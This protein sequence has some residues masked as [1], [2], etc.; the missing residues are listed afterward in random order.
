MFNASGLFYKNTY[1]DRFINILTIS[2]RQDQLLLSARKKIRTAIRTAFL[3]VRQYLTET[4]SEEDIDKI[5]LI[6]PK[7]MSQG[8]YVYKTLNLPCHSCQEIDLDDGVYLPMTFF[9]NQPEANKDWFFAIVDGALKVLALQEGWKFVEKETCARLVLPNQMHIDVPLYAIPDAQ[10]SKLAEAKAALQ[11]QNYTLSEV[12]FGHNMVSGAPYLLSEDE[13]Y[14][15]MRSEPW[16]LSDPL[17]IMLWF[18]QEISVRGHSSG[19]RLRR[20]CRYL[21]AWRDFVW[22][23]GG[24]SSL[25]LMACAVNAYPIDD[26]GRDDYALLQVAKT[27]PQQLSGTI[28]NPAAP[29]EVLYPRGDMDTDEI[30]SQAQL[31][32]NAMESGLS[33]AADKNYLLECLVEHFGSRIPTNAEWIEEIAAAAIVRSTQSIPVKPEIIPNARS[34]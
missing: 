4:V 12:I 5:S 16:K 31:L 10:Y 7:F 33:G 32:V 14:L 21:K 6:K 25:T 18:K 15:A 20:V 19:Q 22:E 29:M 26:H 23:S 11:R 34:A 13:I 17:V 27:L 28:N 24:P 8:S 2:D 3:N 9:K 30:S 1:T